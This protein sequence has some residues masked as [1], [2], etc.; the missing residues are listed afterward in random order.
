MRV[1]GISFY[2]TQDNLMLVV[3]VPCWALLLYAVTFH[4]AVCGSS[5]SASWNLILDGIIA[6]KHPSAIFRSPMC[7]QRKFYFLVS[8]SLLV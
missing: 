1:F 2:Y 3:R 7:P 8:G 5:I 4:C 6:C